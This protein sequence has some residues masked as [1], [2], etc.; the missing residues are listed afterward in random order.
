MLRKAL[1]LRL[2]ALLLVGFLVLQLIRPPLTHPPAVADLQAPPPVKQILKASCYTC[3]SN[4]TQLPWFDQVVPAY[5]LVVHDV[6]EARTHMNF[7]NFGNLPAAQQKAFLFEAVNQAQ[8]GAMPPRRYT[9]VHPWA[10][11]TPDEIAVLKNYLHPDGDNPPPDP[12]QI[13]AADLE[14]KKWILAAASQAGPVKPA[15]NGLAF[16]PDY[17][18]WQ[19][20]STT[21]RF[22]NHTMRVVFGNDVAARAIAENHVH[23]WPDGAAFAKIAWRQQPDGKGNLQTGQFFQVEFMVKDASKYAKTEGWGFSRWRGTDLTPYGKDSS[24]TVECA[25][26]HAMMH[27]ND[28]VFTM[29]IAGHADGDHFNRA[30]ALPDMLPYQPLQWKAITSSIS[31]ANGTMSTLY[32]NDTA[33]THARTG[34]RDPY[35]GGAVLCLVTWRQQEDKHWFGARIPG[36]VQSVEFVTASASTTGSIT[37]AYQIFQGSPLQRLT[38]QQTEPRISAIIS[39]RAAVMP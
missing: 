27:D 36:E 26:C 11:L 33:V 22:D 18:N 24:F 3:H 21:D 12:A 5:W 10:I 25:S 31:R 17:K 30:A 13:T 39:L 8:F 16:V 6:N 37:Y 35:P 14:Y 19:P 4:E 38:T 28:F 15:P 34:P 32:G 7:S 9:L 2:A 20:V 29:P 23:P 1:I